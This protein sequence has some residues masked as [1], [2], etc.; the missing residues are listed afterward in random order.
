MMSALP[1]RLIQ[2][3]WP[4]CAASILITVC[5][6]MGFKY[7]IFDASPR[8]YFID[9]HAP[10]ERFVALEDTYGRDFRVF[11]MLS[12][13]KGDMFSQAHAK[14]LL[15]T[16]EKAWKL[17]FVR[18]VDSIAN[19][20][21]TSSQN[22]ELYVDDFLSED[23]LNQPTKLAERK[24][25]ALNDIAVV[26]RLISDD[27]K[28]AGIILSL[29]VDGSDQD[30]EDA[31]VTEA[32]ALE[33]AIKQQY[34]SIDV[35]ITGNLV[36]TYHSRKIASRDIAIMVP[37]MFL[38]MFILIGA[39]LRSISTVFVALSVAMFAGIGA[40]GL[41]AMFGIEF[42]MLAVNA[43]IISITVAVAHCI[44]IFTQFFTEL[45]TKPKREALATSIRINFFAISMTSLT[46]AIGFLSLNFNDLP[47]AIA[48]GNAAAIGT[49]LAWLYS[50]TMLPALVMLLPFSPPKSEGQFLTHR[51]AS[52][53]EFVIKHQY[54]VLIS[55]SLVTA[56]M[57]ALSFSN[58]LN[59]R[60]SEIIHEPHI[61]RSD[62]NAVDKHFGALYSAHYDLDS[63]ASDN[64]ADPEYL[65]HMDAFATYLRSQPEVKSVYSFADVIKRLNQSMHNDDPAYYKIPDSRELAAQYILL[66]EMSLPFGLDLSDQITMDKQRSR[67]LVTMPAIDT[68]QLKGIEERFW[69]WQQENMPEA[70][71][72]EGASMAIIWAHLSEDSLTNSLKG[73]VIALTLISLILLIVL[74]SLRYGIISLVPNLMPA[75]FGFG[76]WYF[77]S[78]E[79]GIGLTCVIIITI[80]IVV[81][82]TVHFLAKYK[83]AMDDNH[84]NAPDAIR[85]T[86][87]QV[88][89]ALCITTM[90]LAA[91]F[92]VLS[93]SKITGNS[94]LGSVTAIILF[95]AFILDIL[96]LP[97]L[98][99]LIDKH[100]NR[101][102]KAN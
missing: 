18:R 93:L 39:L 80:G 61:F 43:L 7:F 10:Y 11:I 88:G 36:S 75:A 66:Y 35:A 40:L 78:G 82:D 30:G 29:T 68:R 81:D 99:L 73:S 59:D 72:H 53:A 97:A 55:M 95:A 65:K 83:K 19:Y 38:L 41:G 1:Q 57:I 48:L 17:P 47:P 76:A 79:V 60:F 87:R 23:M 31:L 98:L 45:K 22:D 32:Y 12:A 13:K 20:Q 52:L 94:S 100:R 44:H 2:W 84:H 96:L 8:S 34:P 37:T 63:G 16:T 28:H 26:N 67:L 14:A 102:K 90:V 86:F 42:S 51:M 74:R 9:G 33:E 62:T 56:I 91:G 69:A 24:Q 4:L 85:Q 71:I 50:L 89:P 21:F 46:T 5:A 49:G 64:I 58:I 77:M 101:N 25:T 92:L 27:A 70:M 15:E 3:R 54:S 6:F